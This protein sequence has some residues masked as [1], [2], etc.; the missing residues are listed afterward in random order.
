MDKASTLSS[1]WNVCSVTHRTGRENKKQPQNCRKK[2][3]NF[4]HTSSLDLFD[5]IQICSGL[6]LTSNPSLER[7]AEFGVNCTFDQQSAS[8]PLIPTWTSLTSG[9]A[10]HC[11]DKNAGNSM[12]LGL[13]V[14]P[15]RL[16]TPSAPEESQH[17]ICCVVSLVS[18]ARHPKLQ[19]PVPL[20][21]SCLHKLQRVQRPSQRRHC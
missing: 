8:I 3:R 18:S 19:Q 4:L 1:L 11:C 15:L 7:C 12:W 17:R 10:L 13:R 21:S 14:D 6:D 9:R 20:A 2:K 5:L 16:I